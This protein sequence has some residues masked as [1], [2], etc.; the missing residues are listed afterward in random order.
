MVKLS[1]QAK[2]GFITKFIRHGLFIEL[3]TMILSFEKLFKWIA[4]LLRAWDIDILLIICTTLYY[5]LQW[6]GEDSSDTP[7]RVCRN[8]LI[9]DHGTT[10]APL[11]R[12]ERSPSPDMS[13]GHAHDGQSPLINKVRQQKIFDDIKLRWILMNKYSKDHIY[14][15]VIVEGCCTMARPSSLGANCSLVDT[16]V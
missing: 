2:H 7:T 3:K 4:T 15:M 5:W 12:G 13:T 11:L 8:Y 6:M 9:T 14:R 10:G 16:K 1:K